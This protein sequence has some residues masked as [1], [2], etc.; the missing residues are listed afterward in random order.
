METIVYIKLIELLPKKV[1]NFL[2]INKNNRS[3][4]ENYK[5]MEVLNGDHQNIW[6]TSKELFIL[7]Q[8]CL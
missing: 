1:N 7:K 3:V 4:N 8:K 5:T 6:M 2:N